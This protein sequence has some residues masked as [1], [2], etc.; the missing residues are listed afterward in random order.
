[1]L[2]PP[3]GLALPMVALGVFKRMK[4]RHEGLTLQ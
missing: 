1:M 4:P 2:D 3:A